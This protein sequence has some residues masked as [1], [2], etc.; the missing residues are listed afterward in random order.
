ML[1]SGL[2]PRPYWEPDGSVFGVPLKLTFRSIAGLALSGLLTIALSQSPR[3]QAQNLTLEGQT[4]GF[5]TPTAYVLYT[6]K[7]Q[8][9]SHPAV[10]YHFVNAS[11]VIGNI[12]TV[13]VLE[14]FRNR[15]ELGYTRSIHTDGNDATFSAF[16]KSNGM[17][18]F[19]GKVALLSDDAKGWRPGV[20][21][22]G[23]LRTDDKFVSGTVYQELAA[24]KGA[25]VPTKNYTN[26]DVYV[27]VTKTSLRTP[28]PFL[29]NAGFKM[30]NGS[31]FGIGGQ[32]TRFAGSFFGGLGLPL[33]GPFKTAI[34][35]AV[36]ATQEQQHIQ[37]LDKLLVGGQAHI[38]T[39]LDY[40]VRVTQK[41]NPHFALDL[42]VGQVAGRIGSL[43]T[44]LPA[45]YPATV[46]VNLKARNVFGMGLSFRY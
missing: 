41:E 28:I 7:G 14:G 46:P 4:G 45:P 32:S 16:W 3:A 39:T 23:V 11:A 13:S 24:L 9:F 12:H 37:N 1:Q 26:G 25:A 33:P 34:V 42:G 17:N 8:T 29:A 22:G 44:G 30:T 10:G 40:A 35:P 20:A 18:I 36:G 6:A 43:P 38:A 21:V 27:A 31:I 5:I 15:A 19:H 2:H